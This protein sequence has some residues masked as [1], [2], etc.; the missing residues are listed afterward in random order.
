MNTSLLSVAR[1][2]GILPVKYVPY[3]FFV[4][5]SVS[6]YISYKF[7]NKIE[8]LIILDPTRQSTKMPM[9]KPKVTTWLG[10]WWTSL[11]SCDVEIRRKTRAW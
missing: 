11:R 1:K 9:R 3:T 7:V 10:P 8:T 5:V 2:A 6:W 4:V